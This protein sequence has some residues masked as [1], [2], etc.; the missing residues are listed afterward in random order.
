MIKLG[1]DFDLKLDLEKGILFIETRGIDSYIIEIPIGKIT[2]IGKVKWNRRAGEKFKD[3]S[4]KK[5][6][7]EVL[8]DKDG[9]DNI[10]LEGKE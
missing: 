1:R 2:K 8:F 6:P 7:R 10:R 5:P 4:K 3:V 9:K